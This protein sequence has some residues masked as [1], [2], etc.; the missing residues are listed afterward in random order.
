VDNI[1]ESVSEEAVFIRQA[2]Q[3]SAAGW[4]ALVK[5]HQEPV[6]RYAYLLIG[7]ADEAEDIAQEAFIRAYQALGRFDETRPVRPWLLR[8]TAN[9]AHNHHRSAGRY[10]AALRR[11]AQAE[12]VSVMKTEDKAALNLQK[13]A[14]WEAVQ[15]LH[16]SDQQIIYLR[17][18]LEFSIEDTAAAA[19]IAPGTVKS[20]LHRALTRLRSVVQQHYA[21]ILG[22]E[23]G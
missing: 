21:H 14:L 2:R 3:G 12:P 6:F 10:L 16:E 23:P 7:D 9:L 8:I 11:L 13:N 5:M 17:H 19:N 15:R 18:F 20:R 1:P 4:E 22:T